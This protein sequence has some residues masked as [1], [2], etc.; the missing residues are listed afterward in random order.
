MGEELSGTAVATLYLI[1]DEY[2][3][4]S[5]AGIGQFLCKQRLHHLY[6]AHALYA[7]EDDSRDATFHHLAH[8]CLNIVQRQEL[9]MVVVV[10]GG[11]N[12]RI[13][14]HLDSQRGA[15]VEGLVGGEHADIAGLERSQL[16]GVL[17][18]FG[19]AVHKEQLVVVV[20][21]DF[22]Q[23]LS[24]LLLQGVDDGIAVESQLVDLLGDG[25]DVVRMRVADADDG[26]SAI[27]IEVLLPFVVVDVAAL[28][29]N[30]INVEKRIN[31]V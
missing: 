21:R 15:A 18:C 25:L 11:Y 14:A 13:V 4:E 24:Q 16:Q 29:F 22:S 1:A 28:A 27:E 19:T 26:M 7:F 9:R 6:A 5:L 2:H 31:V 17:V 8:P 30:D 3:A 12:L 20:A 23:S 10:D